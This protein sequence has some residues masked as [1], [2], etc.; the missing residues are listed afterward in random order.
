MP[1]AIIAA[2][3][4]VLTSAISDPS[5]QV[6]F[7]LCPK[8]RL[9]M[10]TGRTSTWLRIGEFARLAGVSVKTV[11]Y[12]A[13]TDLV[14]PAFVDPSTSYRFYRSDQ[15]QMLKQ[16]RR[17]RRLGL[18]IAELRSWL[19]SPEG[20]APRINLLEGLERRVQL[21][22][23]ADVERLRTLQLLIEK[24]F[25]TRA[26]RAEIDPKERPI[27][28][29]AAY[30]IRGNGPCAPHTIYRM[31]ESAELQVA[32]HGA[33]SNR[34]PF[35]ILHSVRHGEPP[36]DIEVCIPILRQSI[37]A[38]GGRLIEGTKRAVC[39]RYRGPYDQGSAVFEGMQ[40][41]IRSSGE[42]VTGPLREVYWRY[43][44]DQKGYSVPKSQL[45]R[46]PAD[47]LT[48]IQIPIADSSLTTPPEL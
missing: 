45:A 2:K 40:R 44:A 3:S 17:L 11:R 9:K 1:S 47:Y 21:Q 24:E 25:Q 29:V 41:W 35:L 31:F 7:E 6:D 4:I 12:Y 32:K 38:T 36:T 14:V 16:I 5:K 8:G 28:Q 15:V 33:R 18:G 13:N 48:E 10:G 34:P 30:T 26:L 42:R 37:A 43:G 46:A 23:A 27:S 22:M 39:G 20:S 19:A